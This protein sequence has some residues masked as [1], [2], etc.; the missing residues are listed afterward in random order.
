MLLWLMLVLD[1][2]LLRRHILLLATHETRRHLR[3]S[4]RKPRD[5]KA[6]AKSFQM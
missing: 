3:V 5:T 1:S 4:L 2:R 6:C